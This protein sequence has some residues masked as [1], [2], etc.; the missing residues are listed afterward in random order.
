M[1]LRLSETRVKKGRGRQLVEWLRAYKFFDPAKVHVVTNALDV[2]R[3]QLYTQRHCYFFVV[4][5]D[6]LGCM[7][8]SRKP[9]PGE[10]W[11]RGNDLPD[12]KFSLET[13]RAI[14]GAVVFYEA[15]VVVKPKK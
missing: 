4:K 13:L 3:I 11:T 5:D 12:G 1:I 14:M 7:A 10:D 8:S 6:Y 15:L 9:R 2:F